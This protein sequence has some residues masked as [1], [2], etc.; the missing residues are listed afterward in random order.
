MIV[1]NAFGFKYSVWSCKSRGANA[2]PDG[3]VR[4]V[5]LKGSSLVKAR[6]AEREVVVG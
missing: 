1:G 5:I 3:V 2:K 4:A 6:R